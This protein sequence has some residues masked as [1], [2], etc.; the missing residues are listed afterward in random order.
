MLIALLVLRIWCA[1]YAR[2]QHGYFS[3]TIIHK[4][5][6]KGG[7]LIGLW[8]LPPFLKFQDMMAE[9]HWGKSE[10]LVQILVVTLRKVNSMSL[11][12][13]QDRYGI[14]VESRYFGYYVPVVLCMYRSTKLQT[15]FNVLLWSNLGEVLTHFY[16]VCSQIAI[17]KF[18]N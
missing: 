10:N 18:Q 6:S 11:C 12:C 9:L 4:E 2:H 15:S 14:C 8:H 16:L 5:Q 7:L 3:Q 1:L 17:L 13:T